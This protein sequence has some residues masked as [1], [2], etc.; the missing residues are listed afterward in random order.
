M[1]LKKAFICFILIICLLLPGCG[2]QENEETTNPDFGES[3]NLFA[4]TPDTLNPLIT[5]HQTNA[6]VLSLSYD[7]LLTL[8]N[9]LTVSNSIAES[10]SCNE[11]ASVWIFKLKKG[12]VFSDGSLLTAHN[13]INSI[14]MLR[15]CPE[16]MYYPLMTYVSSYRALSDYELELTLK[17][18]GNTFLPYMNF[19]VVKSRDEVVGTGPYVVESEEKT[20]IVLKATDSTKTNIE[21]ININIYPKNNMKINA[22]MANETDVISADFYELPQLS[23]SSRSTQTEYI[24][25]YFTF[26]GFN[27][28]SETGGDLNIRKAVA[29]LLDKEEMVQSL[30]VGHAKSTNTPYKPG[31]IYSNLNPNDYSCDTQKALSYLEKS[32]KSFNNVSFSILVNNETLSKQQTAEFIAEKLRKA[33]M[34]VTVNAVDYETY[35]QRI[36]DKD[37]VAFIGEFKMPKDYDISFMF[38]TAGNNFDFVKDSFTDALHSFTYSASYEEKVACCKEIQTILLNNVPLV[39]LYYRTNTLLTDSSIEADFDPLHVNIYNGFRTWK[40]NKNN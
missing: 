29:S 15:S 22:Y 18:R 30:F 31:T 38:N 16:N 17:I 35:L 10:Y 7:S 32:E 28:Q 24:S 14:N 34:D 5:K 33:G 23:A 3:I 20:K 25:D 21:T 26:L 27:T 12:Y 8:N 36:K 39:S 2:K 1:K 40:I 19:P 11:D 6:E 9:D 4:Y 13:V 37:F